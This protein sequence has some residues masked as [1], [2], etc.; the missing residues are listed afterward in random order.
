MKECL[1]DI[2]TEL[3]T[4][5]DCIGRLSEQI[6]RL[7]RQMEEAEKH[8]APA[9][10]PET[11]ASETPALSPRRIDRVNVQTSA[12]FRHELSLNDSFRFTR[13]LFEGDAARLG[14]ML[15]A[16]DEVETLEGAIDLFK[17]EVPLLEENE[18]V[19]EFMEILRKHFNAK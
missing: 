13:E 19:A 5:K 10:M 3:Q 12:G 9:S 18:A 15:D 1:D 14:R 8:P 2:R 16:L 17:S 7:E 11:S 6:D 4:L